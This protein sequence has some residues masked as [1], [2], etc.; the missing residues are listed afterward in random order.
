LPATD[1]C[2]EGNEAACKIVEKLGNEYDYL[3]RET[4]MLIREYKDRCIRVK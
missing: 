1:E 4:K 2:L 3:T